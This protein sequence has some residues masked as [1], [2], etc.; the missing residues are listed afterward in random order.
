MTR[1]LPQSVAIYRVG[2]S[3]RDELIG[4]KASDRDFLVVGATPEIM[5]ASG[6]VPVGQDFPVFLHPETNEE[7]ALARTERKHG[8]GYRGF[9]FFATPDVTLE[10]DLRRRDLTINAMARDAEG[11]LVDPFGGEADLRA[12][13]LRH[14]SDAFVDDPL[15]V[16]RVARFAARFAFRIADETLALM[17]DIVASGELATLAP[18]RIWQELSRGLCEAHPSRMLDALRASGAL[19]ALLPEIDALYAIDTGIRGD[20]AGAFTERALD[21]AAD[22]AMSLS[23]RYA[24]LLQELDRVAGAQ[25]FD[26]RAG[27]ARSD[28]VSARLRATVECRDAA[29]VAV[30]GHHA[31]VKVDALTPSAL[32]DLL[33]AADALRRPE[34]MATLSS[35]AAAHVAAAGET[36]A[37]ARHYSGV[38]DEA[39]RVVRDVDAA[40]IARD[41]IDRARDAP[42]E[43]KG[44]A[45]AFALRKARIAALRNFKTKRGPR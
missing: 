14:V 35:A 11:R 6:F 8:R 19:G 29:R 4:R 24:V 32:L 18:E 45:I 31:I 39:L 23:A 2:G 1:P 30:R 25:A 16:L 15:R 3:V 43:G 12:G 22:R 27:V 7:Y 20:N 17:R 10:E 41:A 33:L 34:R 42:R 21:F 26:A 37:D 40:A 9:Q 36:N 44:E 38:L 5:V 13:V 28:A